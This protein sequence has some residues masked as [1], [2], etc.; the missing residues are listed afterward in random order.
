MTKQNERKNKTELELLN[1]INLK[2]DKLI[3]VLAIQSIKDTDDKIHLLKNLDF[4]SDEVGPLVGIK[5]TSV[6]DREGWKRK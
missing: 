6:R 1:D 3:G 4:K 2:L 5:G